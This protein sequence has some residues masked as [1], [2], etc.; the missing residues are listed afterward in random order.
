[1]PFVAVATLNKEQEEKWKLSRVWTKSAKSFTLFGSR[2]QA[3]N[4]WSVL[5]WGTE[6]PYKAKEED[7]SKIYNIGL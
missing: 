1:M 7:D 6:R 4:R 2:S 5:V 3:L